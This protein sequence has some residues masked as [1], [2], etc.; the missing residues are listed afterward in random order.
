[1]QKLYRINNEKELHNLFP[2]DSGFCLFS[3]DKQYHIDK[4]ILKDA[5]YPLFLQYQ[6]YGADADCMGLGKGYEP[7]P[8]KDIEAEIQKCE[9][10]IKMLKEVLDGI[11]EKEQE[12]EQDTETHNLAHHFRLW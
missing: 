10:R 2:N 11:D 12:K 7:I 3:K 4:K 1:M 5:K 6:Y 9:K 8:K